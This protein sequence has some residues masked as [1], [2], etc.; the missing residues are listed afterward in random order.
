MKTA[1]VTWSRAKRVSMVPAWRAIAAAGGGKGP[2]KAKGAPD[3]SPGLLTRGWC[4]F[5]GFS[6]NISDSM[7]S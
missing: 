7:A 1:A 2:A 4:Y 6:S 5:V 3:V